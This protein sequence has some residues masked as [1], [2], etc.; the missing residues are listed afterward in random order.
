M[1]TKDCQTKILPDLLN[2]KQRLPLVHYDNT[3]VL[4]CDIFLDQLCAYYKK[5]KKVSLMI[6]YFHKFDSN[7][8]CPISVTRLEKLI[9]RI[10]Q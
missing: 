9:K 4:D 1:K 8:L 6:K 7:H 5:L 10:R 2:H 3:L